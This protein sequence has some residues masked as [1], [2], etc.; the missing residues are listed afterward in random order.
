M[1]ANVSGEIVA[2]EHVYE[3]HT[4]FSLSDWQNYLSHAEIELLDTLAKSLPGSPRVVNIGAG[5]GTSGLTF[6]QSR[7]DLFLYTIDVALEVNLYG[8]LGNEIGILRSADL[9]DYTR[10][11]PIHQDSVVEGKRW[12][13][14]P[15]DLVFVDGA[16]EYEECRGDL[17]AWWPHLRLGGVMAIHDYRKREVFEAK[18][19]ETEITIELLANLI[20]PYPGVDRATGELLASGKAALLAV[21]DTL[22]AVRKVAE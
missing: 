21:A 10:Y 3:R 17:E 5:A 7:S 12:A 11:Q 19:P 2:S 6:M 22:I 16:H 9:L 1:S 18:H 8:G 20:K 4:P 14:G 13:R 15:V